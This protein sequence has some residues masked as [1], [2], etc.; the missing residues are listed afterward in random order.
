MASTSSLTSFAAAAGEAHGVM[1]AAIIRGSRG[2]ARAT[3]P[4]LERP[5]AQL[6]ESAKLPVKDFEKLS[7]IV[8]L[9][10]NKSKLSLA[11][12]QAQ[13]RQIDEELQRKP[14]AV[15]PLVLAL[16]SIANDSATTTLAAQKPA[17]NGN[18]S[19]KQLDKPTTPV[20]TGTGV[21]LADVAGAVIGGYL[22][23]KAGKSYNIM[24]LTAITAASIASGA[25]AGGE[26]FPHFLSVE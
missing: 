1:V 9:A 14:A 5:L 6:R 23:A 26:E 11:E 19:K 12:T 3:P 16:S 24:I 15:H 2:K 4:P 13:I 21:V 25:I 8:A 7:Q 22:A 20:V 18:K 10:T 17:T